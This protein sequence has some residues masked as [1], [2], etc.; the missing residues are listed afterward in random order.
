MKRSLFIL[1]IGLLLIPKFTYASSTADAI[2]TGLI[3][4]VLILP[5]Y[6]LSL[7][8]YIIQKRNMG[9][10]ILLSVITYTLCIGGILL[11]NYHILKFRLPGFCFEG[12]CI[13]FYLM[14]L[15][16]I[17]II[18]LAAVKDYK[19]RQPIEEEL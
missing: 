10:S 15:P 4:V 19:H 9:R 12:M 14:A 18:I 7:I 3:F 5:Y 2:L 17:I 8:P 6:L 1:L 13:V 16:F 11:S